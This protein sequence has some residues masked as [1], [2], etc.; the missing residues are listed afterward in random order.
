MRNRESRSGLANKR[1]AGELTGSTTGP[2]ALGLSTSSGGGRKMRG[3]EATS[4]GDLVLA[5]EELVGQDGRPPASELAD[6]EAG[7]ESDRLR[8][9]SGRARR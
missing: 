8:R 1:Q 5:L 9:G 3:L 2:L 4:C 7:V 6:C